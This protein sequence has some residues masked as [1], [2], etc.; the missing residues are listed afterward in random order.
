MRADKPCNNGRS[1]PPQV[2]W[3]IC[4]SSCSFRF[5]FKSK[6]TQGLCDC[7][8]RAAHAW[9][10]GASAEPTSCPTR[11]I[12]MIFASLSLSVEIR[13]LLELIYKH[14]GSN[15]A[16][17]ATARAQGCELGGGETMRPLEALRRLPR[18]PFCRP[19]PE[20]K[21]RHAALPASQKPLCASSPCPS[22]DH[23]RALCTPPV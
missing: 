17:E 19:S 1:M 7:D 22:R 20:T 2:P 15:G 10:A 13:V 23:R 21:D 12:L 6:E 4:W 8:I 5:S 9:R 3:Q 14:Y 11:R 18:L 16:S